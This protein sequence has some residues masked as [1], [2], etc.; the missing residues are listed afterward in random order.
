MWSSDWWFSR[1]RE[2]ARLEDAVRKAIEESARPETPASAEAAGA[3]QGLAETTT[4]T[5][6]PKQATSSITPTPPP[7]AAYV[8]AALTPSA[9]G[10][11][12]LYDA[13]GT[14]EV[15]ARVLEVLATE[16]PVHLDELSR[17]V[18]ASFGVGRIT[19]RLRERITDILRSSATAATVR[20]D[21]VWRADQTP[22]SW[23]EVRGP[24]AGGETRAAEQIPPEELAAAAAWV[25]SRCLSTT[26]DDLVRQTARAFGIARAGAR[27][28]ERM[29]AGIAVLEKAGRCVA[30]GDR[31]EW[32]GDAR[33]QR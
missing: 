2:I 27:V 18:G 31:V 8:K 12:A 17:R 19:D 24:S 21:F 29:L 1:E 4:P 22:E 5:P 9:L 14:K 30:Q 7:V 32:R 11:D 15:R 33:T 6:T 25:L 26:Q 13:T 10:V 16:A 23:S 28:T 20:G 3:V